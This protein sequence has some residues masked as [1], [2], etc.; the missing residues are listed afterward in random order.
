MEGAT[1]KATGRPLCFGKTAGFACTA[2]AGCD[3]DVDNSGPKNAAQVTCK[4]FFMG[5][6][7]LRYAYCKLRE[8]L[9]SVG[10]ARV[11]RK[12]GRLRGRVGQKCLVGKTWICKALGKSCANIY[13][14]TFPAS[15]APSLPE[16]ISPE[17]VTT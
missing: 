15:G 11:A 1:R 4:R 14:R 2:A 16:A 17:E 13:R 7:D 3:G 10:S 9:L 8:R 12:E 6:S 5:R